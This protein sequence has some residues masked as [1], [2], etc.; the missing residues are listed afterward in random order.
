MIETTWEPPMHEYGLVQALLERVEREASAHEA[1]AVHRVIVRIGPLAGVDRELF[2]DAYRMCR[3]GT[4]CEDAEL[5]LE[6]E[7]V[8]WR[9]RA[10]NAAIPAGAA[11][12]C[13]TCGWPARLAGGDAIVLERIELE[14]RPHV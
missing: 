11:L 5:L 9:C 1:A 2:A 4:R 7:E 3:P 14:V 10:C 6:T 12:V 13:P 8:D